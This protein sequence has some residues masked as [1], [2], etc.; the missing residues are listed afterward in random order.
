M[1]N[2]CVFFYFVAMKL[3]RVFLVLGIVLLLGFTTWKGF[4][5]SRTATSLGPV[6]DF[7]LRRAVAAAKPGEVVHVPVGTHQ[8]S[9]RIDVPPGVSIQGAGRGKSILVSSFHYPPY[10]GK[11]DDFGYDRAMFTLMS[12]ELTEGNQFIKGLT[13]DGMDKQ[14]WAGIMVRGRKGVELADLEIK[15]MGFFGVWLLESEDIEFRNSSLLDCSWGGEWSMGAINLAAVSEVEMYN[16]EVQELKKNEGYCL[17]TIGKANADNYLRNVKIYQSSFQVYPFDEWGG[18]KSSKITLE[19]WKCLPENL[20]IYDC[21][22]DNHISFMTDVPYGPD[23][24]IHIHHNLFIPNPKN[25]RSYSLEFSNIDHV[26]V[27]HNYVKGGSRF[28]GNWTR[29]SKV[30]DWHIEHNIV[31]D[32]WGSD[33]MWQNGHTT[34]VEFSR[35]TFYLGPKTRQILLYDKWGEGGEIDL[36]ANTIY[37]T[38]KEFRVLESWGPKVVVN[39]EENT[40]NSGLKL[41]GD[42]PFPY[43]ESPPAT[44]AE[45]FDLQKVPHTLHD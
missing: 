9:T 16:L 26:K 33:V 23:Q 43:F 28:I 44:G 36:T 12:K 34:D 20:E 13:L 37:H 32:L 19:F 3:T 6:S 45:A 35:N 1:E 11:K 41:T 40:L 8:V 14:T 10:N 17:K 7:D 18:G 27:D 39:E 42:K 22:F 31:T 4:A 5:V 30:S 25:E 29:G 21:F 24:G 38:H 15:E 2:V